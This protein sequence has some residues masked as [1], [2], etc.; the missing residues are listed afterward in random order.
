MR[1]RRKLVTLVHA[2]EAHK[3][4]PLV[5]RV[6]GLLGARRAPC[7]S[8][9]QQQHIPGL[10]ACS[11]PPPPPRG[12]TACRPPWLPYWAMQGW[13]PAPASPAA[14]TVSVDAP[15]AHQK[16]ARRS[17][18]A[19]TTRPMPV[20]I[21]SKRGGSLGEAGVGAAGARAAPPACVSCLLAAARRRRRPPCAPPAAWERVRIAA[22]GGAAARVL[23]ARPAARA[24]LEPPSPTTAV[25][26]Q[27]LELRWAGRGRRAAGR[28][29]GW[30]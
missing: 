14:R 28:R 5:C 6:A 3:P 20:R 10:R 22:R 2:C 29:H 25:E 8:A 24:Q 17:N 23:A 18:P 12:W 7:F 21:S 19:S 27:A 16:K 11:P 26:R 4:G 13:P 1:G 15:A 9:I 30:R